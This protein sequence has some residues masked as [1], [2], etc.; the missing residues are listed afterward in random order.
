MKKLASCIILLGLFSSTAKAQ[1]CLI[2]M[3]QIKV[4]GIQL[5][6]SLQDILSKH[7]LAREE[8][9]RIEIDEIDSSFEKEG[10]TAVLHIGYNNLDDFVK[11]YALSFSDGKYA[12][13]DT[14]LNDFKSKILEISNVPQTGWVLSQDKASY[15]YQCKDYKIRISQAID[16]R[17]MGPNILVISKYSDLYQD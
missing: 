8:E 2:P 14:P 4:G 17:G 1:S 7:P 16:I 3:H 12:E 6:S 9:E 10:V 11:S 5:M 15:N 13:V